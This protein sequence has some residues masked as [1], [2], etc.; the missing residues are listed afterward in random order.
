MNSDLNELNRLRELEEKVAREKGINAETLRRT[1]A[2]VEE[3][4]ETHRAR[5]LPDNLLKI[6]EDELRSVRPELRALY[7]N[8]CPNSLRC[9]GVE[10]VLIGGRP[11]TLGMNDSTSMRRTTLRP[12][13]MVDFK[14]SF[15]TSLLIAWG[16]TRRSLAASA[17][18]I[19]SFSSEVAKCSRLRNSG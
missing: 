16:E 13:M 12:A 1:I 6:L 17:W 5:G 3:Y 14:R 18:E 4:S 9:L 10:G 8:L 11:P 7:G 2:K 19:H 15:A